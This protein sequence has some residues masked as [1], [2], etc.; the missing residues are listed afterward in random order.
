[1]RK[2]LARG[3]GSLAVLLGAGR[4]ADEHQ[5]RV[6]VARAEDDLSRVSESGQRS[7]T[8]ASL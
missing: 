1:V 6:G 2:P 4:L 5:V 8:E 3:N 7:Q